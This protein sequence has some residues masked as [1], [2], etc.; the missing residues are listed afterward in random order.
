MAAA[1]T[2]EILEGIASNRRAERNGLEGSGSAGFP[3][4]CL[5]GL[6]AHENSLAAAGNATLRLDSDVQTA[7][8]LAYES[9][10]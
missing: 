6:R 10:I 4:G 7:M 1:M 8:Y 9:S 5:A 2:Q 3:A